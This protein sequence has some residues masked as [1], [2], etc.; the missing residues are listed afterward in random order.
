MPRGALGGDDVRGRPGSA[1][2]AAASLWDSLEA[3][4]AASVAETCTQCAVKLAFVSLV[5]RRALQPT[6]SATAGAAMPYTAGF[7]V[8]GASAEALQVLTASTTSPAFAAS[9]DSSLGAAG[10]GGS[11]AAAPAP[12]T[13]PATGSAA[14]GLSSGN[15]AG[16]AIGGT[17]VGL[18]LTALAVRACCVPCRKA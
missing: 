3:S 4:L 8:S 11:V 16:L 5:R 9:L 6:D 12:A 18:S 2:P 14:W 17:L 15:I 10:V 7:S 1:P 13:P